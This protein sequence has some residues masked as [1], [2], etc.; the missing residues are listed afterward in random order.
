LRR[1]SIRPRYKAG[2]SI[3]QEP[4]KA[5]DMRQRVGC[6]LYRVQYAGFG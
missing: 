2:R 5:G 6:G 3:C 1:G 4:V